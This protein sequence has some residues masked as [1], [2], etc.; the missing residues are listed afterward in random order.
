MEKNS[1]NGG[2]LP[3]AMALKDSLNQKPVTSSALRMLTP[4]QQELL[5]QW[6]NEVDERLAESSHL[7]ALLARFKAAAQHV[8]D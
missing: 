5:R 2:L 4:L 7:D 6:E 3:S 1:N 8:A